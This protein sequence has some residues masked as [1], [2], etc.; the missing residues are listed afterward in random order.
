MIKFRTV[1]ALASLA[2]ALT[3]TPASAVSGSWDM[4]ADWSISNGN[5]NGAWVYGY[6]E[7]GVFTAFNSTCVDGA[8]VGTYQDTWRHNNDYDAWGNFAKVGPEGDINAWT[9]Y[10]PAGTCNGGPG[11]ELRQTTAVWVA[12]T[13]GDYA[14]NI[15]IS[16]LSVKAEGTTVDAFVY[17]NYAQI[18]S[19]EIRGFVGTPAANFTDGWGNAPSYTFSQTMSFGAGDTVAV[20]VNSGPDGG[21][22]DCYGI[23]FTVTPVPEPSSILSLI[24][25]LG[26]TGF[27]LRRKTH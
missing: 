16:G 18:A 21:A 5:P 26:T 27:M 4:A 9:S 8:P 14:V 6:L 22:A 20:G 12:P 7:A 23:A 13:A 1:L 17:G 3:I 10:R 2:L 11:A 25:L 19:A 15:V 24:G